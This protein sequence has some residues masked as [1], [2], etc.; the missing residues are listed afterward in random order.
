M[1]VPVGAVKL[2]VNPVVVMFDEVIPVGGAGR[3]VIVT[4][5]DAGDIRCV[6]V[7][8]VILAVAVIE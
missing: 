4:A 5:V 8:P 1:A 2:N 7:P 3:V 6:N